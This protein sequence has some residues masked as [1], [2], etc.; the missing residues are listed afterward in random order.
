MNLPCHLAAVSLAVLLGFSPQ[1]FGLASEYPPGDQISHPDSWPPRLLDL[2][3]GP[4]R[5]AG[6]F[7]NSD[8]YFAFQGDTAG[9]QRSLDTCIVFREFGKTTLH[10]H[11]GKGAFQPLAQAR[12]AVPCDWRLDIIDEHFRGQT[13][14]PPHPRYHMHLHIWLGGAVKVEALKLPAGLNVA[15]D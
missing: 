5:V 8:D 12:P 14:E 11:Q 10:L 15:K 7:V 13:P 1:A 4:S 2:V 9:F 3:K 6:Y